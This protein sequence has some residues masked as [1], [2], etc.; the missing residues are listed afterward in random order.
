M[1]TVAANGFHSYLSV[2]E[3]R[4]KLR[5]F[6]STEFTQNNDYTILDEELASSDDLK[7][8]ES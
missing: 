5:G 3:T 2:S 6:H 8:N 4:R 1:L 7:T